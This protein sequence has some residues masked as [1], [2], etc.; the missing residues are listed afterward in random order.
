MKGL[1]VD[2]LELFHIQVNG[3]SSSAA[4]PTVPTVAPTR[5]LALKHIEM[6]LS[7]KDQKVRKSD[8]EEESKRPKKLSRS[9]WR[10]SAPT[11]SSLLMMSG[12]VWQQVDLLLLGR[13][14]VALLSTKFILV[15][16]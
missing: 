1:D 4:A 10:R 3:R 16:R 11:P 13:L 15:S 12:R 6:V 7:E 9:A 5:C 2:N 14:L 8:E